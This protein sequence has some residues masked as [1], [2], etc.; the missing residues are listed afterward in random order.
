MISW[1]I[2][3]SVSIALLIVGMVNKIE[4]SVFLWLFCVS[5]LH[6]LKE[7]FKISTEYKV[8]K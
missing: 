8:G 1:D 2:C 4:P 7:I 6:L 3:A 5:T